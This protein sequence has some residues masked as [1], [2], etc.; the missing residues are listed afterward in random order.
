MDEILKSRIDRISCESR[1][2]RRFVRR[3]R[4][5]FD[6]VSKFSQESSEWAII[7]A[8]SD[9]EHVL[10]NKRRISRSG[11][12]RRGVD[13]IDAIQLS[14][15]ATCVESG[16]RIWKEK[17]VFG[18][19]TVSHKKSAMHEV[20]RAPFA[21][22]SDFRINIPTWPCPFFKLMIGLNCK[23]WWFRQYVKFHLRCDGIPIVNLTI[24]E[25]ATAMY[26]HQD[27]ILGRTRDKPSNQIRGAGLR[28]LGAVWC[29]RELPV[30]C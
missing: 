8:F 24:A 17:D 3:E 14:M 26:L 20:A 18:M 21:G 27:E 1:W 29:R 9:C 16:S 19:T 13:S 15:S 6:I 10:H 5:W 25:L 4:L 22:L 12:E 30:A 11:N 23:K 2:I 28:Y 7:G